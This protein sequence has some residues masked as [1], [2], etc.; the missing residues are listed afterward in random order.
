MTPLA[1]IRADQ[2]Y[3]GLQAALRARWKAL[4]ISGE[5]MDECGGLAAAYASKLLAP[6]PPKNIGGSS[7]GA[8]MRCLGIMLVVVEDEE[9]LDRIVGRSAGRKNADETKPTRKRRRKRSKLKG[10]SEWGRAM[11]A[12][13]MIV[14]SARQRQQS[15]RNASRARWAKSK[16]SAQT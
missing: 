5:D 4:G 9:I 13:R 10:N 8:I 15:G 2:G 6:H 14:M 3:D 16:A 7:L 1:I 12:R 11:A